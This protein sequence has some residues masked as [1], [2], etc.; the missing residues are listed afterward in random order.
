[1][2]KIVTLTVNPVLGKNTSVNRL[3]SGQ[4]LRCSAPVF[5]AGGGGI[6]VSRAIQ[7]LGGAS[8]AIYLAG[9]PCGT[10]LEHLMT[11]KRIDQKKVGIKG[12]TRENTTVLDHAAQMPYHFGDP[13]PTV[14]EDEWQEALDLVE[15]NLGLGDY[16]VASGKLT[17]GIP[18]DFYVRVAELARSKKARLVLDTKGPALKKAVGSEIFLLKPNLREL[19]ELY[20]VGS[21]SHAELETLAQKFIGDHRCTALVVSMGARGA[22]LATSE[23]IV[24]VSAPIVAQKSM[25]GAGDSMVAGMV[26]AHRA[27]KDFVDMMR[28]G[29]ACGSAATLKPGAQLCQKNDVDQLLQSIKFC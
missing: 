10:I 29:V 15:E 7:N 20:G 2:N 28:Y 23:T 1:M 14:F 9:G 5:Y 19:S 24:H 21:L 16:L 3:V 26:L 18:D 25:I 13:G 11:A 8:L 17:Y 27:G 6:N 22:L 4:K 12:S